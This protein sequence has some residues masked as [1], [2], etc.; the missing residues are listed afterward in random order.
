SVG[1]RYLETVSA[2]HDVFERHANGEIGDTVSVKIAGAKSRSEVSPGFAYT[3]VEIGDCPELVR[4][5]NGNS[6]SSAVHYLHASRVVPHPDLGNPNRQIGFTVCVEVT[7]GK[8][9]TERDAGCPVAEERFGEKGLL[10]RSELLCGAG[11]IATQHKNFAGAAAIGEA[12]ARYT[13]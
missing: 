11:K 4:V 3:V 8:D 12:L 13:N 5:T 2:D 9:G 10:T 7:C 1:Q 6:I